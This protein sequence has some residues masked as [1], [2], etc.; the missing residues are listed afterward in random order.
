MVS[1]VKDITGVTFGSLTAIKVSH[2][3][4]TS[5]TIYWLYSCVCGAEHVARGNVI[6]HQSKKGDPELPSCGCI[7]LSRKT[8]HG[9]RKAN[10]THPTYKVWRSMVNRC[11]N[12][13]TSGYE[14]YGGVGVTVCDEWKNNPALFCAWAINNGWREGLHIDK[15]ILCKKNGIYPH[16]YS[17]STCQFVSAKVNVGD[18]TNRN[19]YGKHPNIRLSHDDVSEIRTLFYSGEITNKSEIARIYSV[20]PSTIRTLL[21]T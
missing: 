16:V 12:P 15:D 9:F 4:E 18:A 3:D 14:W 10:D 7:E 6:T 2:K 5:R 20:T 21:E 13:N 19:N 8:K 11:Y 1:R 17:P